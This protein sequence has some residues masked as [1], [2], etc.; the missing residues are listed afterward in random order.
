M[1]ALFGDRV[2]AV[3]HAEARVEDIVR[4]LLHGADA[5]RWWSLSDDFQL[6]AEAAPS[7]FLEAVEDSL[8]QNEPAIKVLYGRDPNPLFGGD[9]IAPLLWALGALGWSP[10]L[11]VQSQPSTLARLIA[12]APADHKGNHP[13][14]TLREMFIFWNPQTYATLQQRFRVIDRLRKEQPVQAWRLMLG[15]L[16]GHHDSFMFQSATRWRDFTPDE[17]EAVAPGF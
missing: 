3:S 7:A 14:D 17:Q 16:P 12:A 4:T 8:L 15:I 5:Q 9:H 1:L 13:N 11:S 10:D 6:L 2:S